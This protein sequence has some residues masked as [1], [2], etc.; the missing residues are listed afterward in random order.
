MGRERVVDWIGGERGGRFFFILDRIVEGGGNKQAL[1]L[2]PQTG[3]ELSKV[4]NEAPAG[5]DG[6]DCF[7]FFSTWIFS[8][9][10]E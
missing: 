1:L 10:R 9:S 7:S 8:I 3:I 5:E 4:D 2:L 6:L